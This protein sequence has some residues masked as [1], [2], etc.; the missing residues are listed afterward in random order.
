LKKLINKKIKKIEII[1]VNMK[2]LLF[3]IILHFV[4]SYKRI[5]YRNRVT[6]LKC[7]LYPFPPEPEPEDDDNMYSYKPIETEDKDIPLYIVIW[8]KSKKSKKLLYEMEKQG[9]HTYFIEDTF[10]ILEKKMKISTKEMPV[11]YKNDVLLDGWMD[12]YAEMYPM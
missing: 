11:V 3:I 8:D 1:K 4:A 5:Y 7:L 6:A 10:D 12:I 9:L 2:F